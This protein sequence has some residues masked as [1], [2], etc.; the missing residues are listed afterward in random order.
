M[1]ITIIG[2]GTSVPSLKRASP[3][4]MISCP[5][6]RILCDTGP[7]TLRQLQKSGTSLNDIDLLAYSHFHVDHISDLV[8][9]IFAS[10]YSPDLARKRDLTIIGPGGIRQFYDRLVCAY[11]PSIGGTR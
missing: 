1:E 4:L 10:K 2:S 8:P 7:G 3:A 9:F 6:I 5:N 11:G